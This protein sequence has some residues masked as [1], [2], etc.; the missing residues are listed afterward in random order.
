MLTEPNTMVDP[1]HDGLVKL[2]FKCLAAEA[3]YEFLDDISDIPLAP[4]G[5]TL[6]S[7]STKWGDYTFLSTSDYEGVT[8]DCMIELLLLMST[9]ST[10][11]P[12]KWLLWLFLIYLRISI[13]EFPTIIYIIWYC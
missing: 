10:I 1:R 4:I 3:L 9:S 7:S 2:M 5:S 6:G 8:D 13:I 11:I 12:L